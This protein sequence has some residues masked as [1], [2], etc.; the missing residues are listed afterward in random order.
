MPPVDLFVYAAEYV[1]NKQWYERVAHS[2][3]FHDIRSAWSSG[4]SGAS[5]FLKLTGAA[6]RATVAQMPIP[7]VGGLIAAV[8][9]KIETGIRQRH[10]ARKHAQ[11]KNLQDKV[12][13]ELKEMSVEELDRYRWKVSHSITEFN[14]VATAFP[15][16][17][18]KKRAEHATCDAYLE[19]AIAAEQ[20]TRRIDKLK[21]H[22]AG[23]TAAM[24]LTADW[25]CECET[26]SVP[27]AGAAPAAP[28]AA[29]PPA[30]GVIAKKNEVMAT[31]RKC[32]DDER[33]AMQSMVQSMTQ[34][35]GAG[36]PTL[37][38]GWYISQ[39]H[40]NCTRWCC[41]RDVSMAN[42]T[43]WTPWFA[44]VMKTLSDPFA[45]DDFNN[46]LKNLWDAGN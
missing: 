25:I 29:N 28:A 2:A 38:E 12:K 46:N 26:G 39:Y 23:I 31:I 18:V 30:G 32:L 20:V 21:M 1:N 35:P 7:V 40:G 16:T 27:A 22:C 13:F 19:L 24:K 14:R 8:E 43:N 15:A 42:A 37:Y 44:E 4:G 11:A 33:A 6:V 17:Y 45:P 3:K 10:H 36:P 34:S 5:K 9:R 41:F